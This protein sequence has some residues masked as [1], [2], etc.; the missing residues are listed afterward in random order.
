MPGWMLLT[1]NAEGIPIAMFMDA[2]DTQTETLPIIMDE[3]V[4]SDTIL[5]VVKISKS[6]FLVYDILVFNGTQIHGRKTYKER[7]ALI[8]DLLGLFHSTD[9]TALFH[10]DDAPVGTVVRGYEYYDEMPGSIGIFLEQMK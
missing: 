10:V 9:L 1:H 5:R 4:C 6:M 7:S 8:S 2:K 3:R